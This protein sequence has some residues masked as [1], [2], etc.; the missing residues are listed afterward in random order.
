MSRT[1]SQIIKHPNYN[2]IPNDNDI[3]LLKLSS[4]VNFTDYIR[5]VC[6]AA[7][8]SVFN[9]GTTC[10]VTG[11]G[12][13]Q[14]GVSLPYPQNL[15]EVSVPIVSNDECYT[16]YGGKITS[17]MICA[18]VAQGGKDSCQGDS[19]GPLVTK[20]SSTWVQ[21]GVVSFGELCAQPNFPGVYARVS[22]YHSWINSHITTDQPRFVFSGTVHLV[23]LSLPLLLSIEP[24]LFSLFLL[25]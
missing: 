20:T 9:A 16:A 4:P 11:W 22:Q 5:P 6:L 19:G 25:S 14:Y 3:A 21:A 2:K 12:D 8:G 23:S 24:V 1:V 17:N 13:I 10:W 15:Q 18:G 7:A